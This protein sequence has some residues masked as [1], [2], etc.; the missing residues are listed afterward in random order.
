MARKQRKQGIT[1]LRVQVQTRNR[2]G[3]F[4]LKIDTY[5]DIIRK[6]MDKVEKYEKQK[7]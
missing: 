6:L 3:G 4:G 2:L 5:D 7:R 1:T